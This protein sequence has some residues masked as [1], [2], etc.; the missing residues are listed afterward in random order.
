MPGLGNDPTARI[1]KRKKSTK[2]GKS[3]G[4]LGNDPTARILKP[5]RLQLD[6]VCDDGLGNDPTARI[7]KPVLSFSFTLTMLV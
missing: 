3:C 6:I 7:L 5:P 4:G 1:L 2:I